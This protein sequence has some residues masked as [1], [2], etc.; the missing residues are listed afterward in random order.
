MKSWPVPC[1]FGD[2]RLATERVT[3]RDGKQLD[4]CVLHYAEF[5]LG[6]PMQR[7]VQVKKSR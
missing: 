5:H 1:Y 7:R 6:G 4:V 3:D 2:G